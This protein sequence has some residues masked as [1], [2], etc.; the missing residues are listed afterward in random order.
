MRGC[1]M[2]FI[3]INTMAEYRQFLSGRK[4]LNNSF[5]AQ[6]TQKYIAREALAGI[7]SNFPVLLYDEKKY[8]QMCLSVMNVEILSEIL[9][10]VDK[11]VVSYV[12]E[13]CSRANNNIS[14][15][16]L[17]SKSGFVELQT[18]YE[19][20]LKLDDHSFNP[21]ELSKYG[22]QK[23][24][25]WCEK[26][27]ARVLEL[28]KDNI[29]MYELPFIAMED[30]EAYVC[31][32]QLIALEDI[33]SQK[34][35]AAVCFETLLGRSLIRH[36]VVDKAYR[37]RGFGATLL[38]Q[39]LAEVQKRGPKAWAWVAETNTASR[40]TFEKNGFFITPVKMYQYILRR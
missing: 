27:Y 16:E 29:P 24:E 33:S 22:L 21:E 28:W 11:T 40:K 7:N 13:D 9:T 31:A 30:I 15:R 6:E 19:F 25:V 8:Y 20:R 37:G 34:T 10:T 39:A 23:K 5:T 36:L 17:L 3:Q 32:G 2:D 38:R 4:I 14:L 35:V 12:R 26:D 18:F 1:E